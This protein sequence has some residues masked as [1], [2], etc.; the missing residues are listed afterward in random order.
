[1]PPLQVHSK[2]RLML[3]ECTS[4]LRT[5]LSKAAELGSAEMLRNLANVG[6]R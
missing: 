2:E 1:M 6:Y 4:L 5:G 3:L